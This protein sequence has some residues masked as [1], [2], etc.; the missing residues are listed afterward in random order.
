MYYLWKVKEGR[1]KF[2]HKKAQLSNLFD[3]KRLE[4]GCASLEKEEEILWKEFLEKLQ[5]L[6]ATYKVKK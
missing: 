2:S 4:E 5:I 1:N 6:R 3:K